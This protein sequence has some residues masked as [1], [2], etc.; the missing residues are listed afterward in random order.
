MLP[1]LSRTNI[2]RLFDEGMITG[3]QINPLSLNK[4]PPVGTLLTIIIP[5]SKDSHH[6][7]EEIPLEIL[8]EDNDILFLNKPAG[9]VVHPAP[10]NE[11]GTLVNALLHHCPHLQGI[12]GVKRPGIVHR[13]DQ[14]TSGV[15]IVA[16]SELAHHRLVDTFKEH[17][18][19]RLYECIAVGPSV[20]ARGMI[21]ANIGRHP[22]NR[23]KMKANVKNGKE[24]ITCYRLINSYHKRFHHLELKLETGRTHQIR[25]HLSQMLKVPIFM[26]ALYGNVQQQYSFAPFPF[27]KDYPYPL[28]HA[29][30]LGLHHPISGEWVQFSTPLPSIFQQTLEALSLC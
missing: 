14:G 21:K 1:H 25:V 20:P 10:G 13:L 19:E 15:M 16:K 12:G 4:M 29:K 5:D 30:T 27:L 22:Q 6:Q 28:L 24:A 11:S 23:L 8:F 3:N 26:D 17:K 18:L 2:K 9:L 7:A